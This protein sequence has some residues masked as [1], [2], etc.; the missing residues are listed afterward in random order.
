M[1]ASLCEMLDTNFRERRPPTN[2]GNHAKRA[3]PWEVRRLCAKVDR[4]DFTV[5]HCCST[6]PVHTS[7]PSSAS[8]SFKVTLNVLQTNALPS[9]APSST[10][11]SSTTENQ[12]LRLP[13]VAALG[14]TPGWKRGRVHPPSVSGL[15]GCRGD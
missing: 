1:W 11:Q 5:L 3:A 14:P 6:L 2:F 8:W 13:L 4:C 15:V 12:S 7:Y 9:L 10:H